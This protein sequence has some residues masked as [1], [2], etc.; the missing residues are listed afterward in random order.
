[1]HVDENNEKE[2]LRL[3]AE[4]DE[5]AYRQLFHLHW[6]N[7]YTVALVLTKSVP[8][9]EDMVQD[10]FLKVWQKRDQFGHVERFE[11]YLFMMAR[12][13]IFTELKKKAKDEHF[14]QGIIDYFESSG[15]H[16]DLTLLT[17]ETQEQINLAIGQLTPQQELVYRLSRDQGL[18]HEE[19][20]HQLN[21]SRNT[22][23]NHI[24]QSLKVIRDYLKDNT[25]GAVLVW[26]LLKIFFQNH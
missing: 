8:L 15:N 9:A 1:M 5:T 13:H 17:K 21:I 12:N 16:A 25:S 6:N 7:V 4:G 10:V 2:L 26:A 11:D 20:A 14:K 19:I 24:V 18:S 23:R 3:V 22:V